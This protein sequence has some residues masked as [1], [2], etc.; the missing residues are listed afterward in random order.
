M[1]AVLLAGVTPPV[2][3]ALLGSL[4]AAAVLVW[5]SAPAGGRGARVGAR[6][7]AG[8]RAGGTALRLPRR[9]ADRLCAGRAPARREAQELALLDGLAAALEAGLPTDRAVTVALESAAGPGDDAWRELARAAGE[10]QPLGAAWQRV[11]RR[12]GSPTAATVA[13][14]WSVAASTGA[15]VAAAVRSAAG[16]ARERRR[17]V[18]AV[19]VASA[20]ARAT[21]SVLGLLPLAGVGL[22]ALLGVGPTVLYSHPLPLASAG[23]GLVLL[24]LGHLLVRRLV[25]QVLRRAA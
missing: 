5:P 8:R 9:V 17:L 20:G 12:T 24:L 23:L 14:A 19:D 1:T 25:G 22:A 16:T 18:G 2:L 6:A 4:A 15:P 3:S 21:A 11:A 13:R 7:V 10:G